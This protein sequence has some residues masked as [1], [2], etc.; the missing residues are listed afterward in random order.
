MPNDDNHTKVKDGTGVILCNV[1]MSSVNQKYQLGLARDLQG[2]PELAVQDTMRDVVGEMLQLMSDGTADN[3]YWGEWWYK[4][5]ADADESAGLLID[6]IVPPSDHT[7]GQKQPPSEPLAFEKREWNSLDDVLVGT[8]TPFTIGPHQ[9]VWVEPQT[10][11]VLK[12]G[13]SVGW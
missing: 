8:M 5:Q 10:L 12:L 9:K 1:D 6:P 11:T 13:G 4:L 2:L 3:H 7:F